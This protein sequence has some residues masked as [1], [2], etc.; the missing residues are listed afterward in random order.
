MHHDYAIVKN[1]IM[2]LADLWRWPRGDPSLGP[3]RAVDQLVQWT[4]KSWQLMTGSPGLHGDL[5]LWFPWVL[6]VPGLSPFGAW[7]FLSSILDMRRRWS[8]RKGEVAQIITLIS[9]RAGE[10]SSSAPS[11][12]WLISL[13]IAIPLP[14]NNSSLWLSWSFSSRN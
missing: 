12:Q 7:V 2:K 6:A 4:Q 5:Q 1:Y 13:T 8:L 10:A 11:L 9:I 14:T 3:T